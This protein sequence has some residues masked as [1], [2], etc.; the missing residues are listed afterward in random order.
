MTKK[1][2]EVL[3]KASKNIRIRATWIKAI[4][5]DSESYRCCLNKANTIEDILKF[6]NGQESEIQ[7]WADEWAYN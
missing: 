4:S 2:K 3:R 1:E 6:G 5:G 7:R